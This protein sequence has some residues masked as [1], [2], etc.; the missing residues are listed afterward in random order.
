MTFKELLEKYGNGTATAEEQAQV[1]RE[2]EKYEAVTAFYMNETETEPEEPQRNE[3]EW[4]RIQGK[5]KR[6]K[7]LLGLA[8]VGIAAVTAVAALWGSIVM[9]TESILSALW[10]DPEE[11][12]FGEEFSSDLTLA[13]DVATELYMPEVRTEYVLSE[14]TGAG[15]YDLSIQQWDNFDGEIQYCFGTVDRGEIKLNRDF[16]KFGSANLFENGDPYNTGVQKPKTEVMAQVGMLP[17]YVQCETYVSFGEDVSMDVLAELIEKYD[18]YAYW[19]GVRVAPASEQVLPAT[20]FNPSGGGYIRQI[21][22][23][24]YPYYEIGWQDEGEEK[25]VI[26]EEHFKALLRMAM[27]ENIY[28][29]LK[30]L[31]FIYNRFSYQEILDYVEKNGVKSYGFAASLTKDQIIRLTAE[32]VVSGFYIK[33]LKLEIPWE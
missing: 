19:V 13:L 25:S 27:D 22:N 3:K 8:I 4:E 6:R 29:L 31:D 24:K 33:D 14:R 16:I 1:E 18:L 9:N 10:Y 7:I 15:R 32:D 20:G 2:L 30:K 26:L 28:P 23:E 5:L 21:A 12:N 17:E 11:Q